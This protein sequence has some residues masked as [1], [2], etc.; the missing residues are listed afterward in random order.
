MRLWISFFTLFAA[1]LLTSPAQAC[2]C[3]EYSNIQQ[4]AQRKNI[5][6]AKVQTIASH[7]GKAKV[8]IEKV[9]KGEIDKVYLEIQG[10][11]GLNC[12]GQ[13]FSVGETGVLLFQKTD[14]GYNTLVCAE[15]QALQDN[16]G[17][18]NINL[19]ENF[20][21]TE[22]ELKD[23]L[24][25]KLRA[26]IKSAECQI[27]VDRISV[28]F[29]SAQHMNFSYR[30]IVS[31]T[32]VRG[33]FSAMNTTVDLS[34]MAPQ[35][36]ELNFYSEVTTLTPLS[37]QFNIRLKDPFTGLIL[38]NWSTQLD[39]RQ[40]LQ[41]IGPSLNRFTDLAGNPMHQSD[42]PFL[43]HETRSFCWL[44]QGKPLELVK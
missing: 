16:A 12:N 29:D 15:T 13:N 4:A 35:I 21:L 14:D 28:P 26:T 10:Q 6:I 20:L 19:G 32:A 33:E 9:F 3:M 11:D 18:Y 44:N 34:T 24:D 22:T 36:H 39:P 8:R 5:I 43:A 30:T 31:A 40:S 17:L 25:F 42:Q 23:V 7:D 38:N 1:Y 41:F 27:N 2:S 37:Y